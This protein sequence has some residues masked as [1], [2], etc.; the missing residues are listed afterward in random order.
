MRRNQGSTEYWALPACNPT[1]NVE[2][3]IG[4]ATTHEFGETHTSDLQVQ[5]KT[6]F[7]ALET[8]S[9]GTGVAFG[10]LLARFGIAEVARA[11]SR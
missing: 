9:W 5:A 1:G 4:G 7:K 6:L 10:S 3:T 8:N 2:L 11:S